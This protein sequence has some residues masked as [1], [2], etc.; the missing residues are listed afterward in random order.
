MVRPF[1]AGI[2]QMAERLFCTQNVVGSIPAIG[3]SGLFHHFSPANPL[4][5]PK[6][7]VLPYTL[8]YADVV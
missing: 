8:H 3:S 1:Y 7:S 4:L 2:A 5:F 6:Q